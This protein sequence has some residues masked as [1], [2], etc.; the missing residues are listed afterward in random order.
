[1]KKRIVTLIHV[2]LLGC[3]ANSLAIEH[4]QASLFEGIK[5]T[6]NRYTPSFVKIPAQDIQ[7]MSTWLYKKALKRPISAQEDKKAKKAF[8]R[9]KIPVGI[10]LTA[11]I[12]AFL[13]Y[14]YKKYS[15]EEKNN[16]KELDT[17]KDINPEEEEEEVKKEDITE[18]EEK[19]L[20]GAAEI[21]DENKVRAFLDKGAD[22]EAKNKY[23]NTAL[24]KAA[25]NGHTETVKALLDKDADP[26]IQNNVGDTALMGAVWRGGR[27]EIVKALL[28]KDADP[29]IQNEHGNTALVI[30]VLNGRTEIV[31]ALLDKGADIEAK[32]DEGQ[33][34]LMKAEQEG[35]LAI[36]EMLRNATEN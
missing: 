30:A 7:H 21:G 33:T 6:L 18:V 20:L 3:F 4:Q 26:N 17:D 31:E 34:A 9:W 12:S 23:G 25:L 27:T 10:V 15:Y 8:R 36:I 35:D 1:M 14:K 2:F 22:I 19:G 28:D 5:T 29:N 11:I 16:K 32:N 13:V 24:M